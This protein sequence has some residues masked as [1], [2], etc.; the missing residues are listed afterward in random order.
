MEGYTGAQV[1]D[2]RLLDVAAVHPSSV[3]GE[4]LRREPLDRFGNDPRRE[5]DA[6]A[7]FVQYA[8]NVYV[9][10]FVNGAYPSLG[11]SNILGLSVDVAN[12][13]GLPKIPRQLQSRQSDDS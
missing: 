3:H 11:I 13:S 6:A 4:R 2:C 8:G 12:G 7:E 9:G 10:V 5:H 1:V